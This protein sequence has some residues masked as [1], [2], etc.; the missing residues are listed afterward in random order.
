MFVLYKNLKWLQSKIALKK[1]ILSLFEKKSRDP[2]G[3]RVRLFSLDPGSRPGPAGPYFQ[4]TILYQKKHLA[5]NTDQ[6]KSTKSRFSWLHRPKETWNSS[7]FFYFFFFPKNH[8][9]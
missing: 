9:K 8:Q 1:K 7:F 4:K 6:K 3:T 2:P 5:S